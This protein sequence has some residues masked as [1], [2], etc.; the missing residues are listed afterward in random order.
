[1]VTAGPFMLS[2]LIEL[3]LNYEIL[4]YATNPNPK[5]SS[6]YV[7]PR[8]QIEV[9][10]AVL[11]GNL[12]EECVLNSDAEHESATNEGTVN[13]DA[14]IDPQHKLKNS[15]IARPQ[16]TINSILSM[17]ESQASFGSAVGAAVLLYLGQFTYTLLSLDATKGD[18]ATA[19]ALAFGIWWMT[20]VHVSVIG[21]SLLASN[22]PSTAAAI[23]GKRPP[24]K[25]ACKDRELREYNTRFKPAWMF[26][27]GKNKIDWLC[28]TS[29]WR[30]SNF[31]DLIRISFFL[32]MFLII[33]A[34]ALLGLPCG[35]A[36]WIEYR[37]PPVSVGCRTMTIMLYVI[38]QAVLLFFSAFYH[39]RAFQKDN[40]RN[41]GHTEQGAQHD[42]TE[43]KSK[44]RLLRR[45]LFY[46]TLYL[47]LALAVIMTFVGTLMQ[48]TGIF[49]NCWCADDHQ[50]SSKK[51]AYVSLSTDT[52]N[53][54][55]SAL[56]W[57]EAG[58]TAVTFFGIVAYGGWWR[59][60]FIRDTFIERGERLEGEL[61]PQIPP[62]TLS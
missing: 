12:L 6:H 52:E 36:I 54:R 7:A 14:V 37:T 49:Q 53:D 22:N 18:K 25:G 33:L 32:W 1:M 8:E 58:G 15:F 2:G 50:F 21:A 59:Q 38:A 16:S 41:D 45:T 10:T 40:S 13:E 56:P 27:R 5:H 34:S 47:F 43:R 4:R 39:Y 42:H 26:P 60:R 44:W 55:E 51:S 62:L 24:K 31:R 19:R 46:F 3:T 35:L 29:A 17:L 11:A 28:R 30:H 20:M 9:L 57:N 61:P 23:V 48:I